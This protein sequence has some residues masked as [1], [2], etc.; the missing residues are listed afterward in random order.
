M[1]AHF[2][3]SRIVADLMLRCADSSSR[4]KKIVDEIGLQTRSLNKVVR[5]GYLIRKQLELMKAAFQHLLREGTTAR[6]AEN[7]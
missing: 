1:L 6:G 5:M 4:A 3:K 7:K 2:A